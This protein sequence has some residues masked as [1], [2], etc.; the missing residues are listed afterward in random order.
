MLVKDA[1]LS[2][3]NPRTEVFGEWSMIKIQALVVNP[4]S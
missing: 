4:P 3:V 2:T 1:R